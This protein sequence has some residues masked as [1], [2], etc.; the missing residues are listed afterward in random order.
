MIYFPETINTISTRIYTL[1]CIHFHLLAVHINSL[2]ACWHLEV[3][4]GSSSLSSC[5]LLI[6]PRITSYPFLCPGSTDA[7]CSR[8]WGPVPPFPKM[9]PPFT[10]SAHTPLPG[11]T[12]LLLCQTDE[13]LLHVLMWV[14]IEQRV[15]KGEARVHTLESIP[16]QTRREHVH[17][18]GSVRPTCG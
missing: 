1:P 7:P 18:R 5:R 16:N 8:L 12:T 3:V 10:G 17:S 11:S 2:C 13:L 6:S 4:K 14:T 9:A 15:M